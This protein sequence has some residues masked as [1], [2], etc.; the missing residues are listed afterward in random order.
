MEAGMPIR[1]GDTVAI[2]GQV[3]K[4][5]D[6]GYVVVEIEGMKVFAPVVVRASSVEVIK[7]FQPRDR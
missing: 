2:K 1:A 7:K 3:T 6:D 5:L 4:L